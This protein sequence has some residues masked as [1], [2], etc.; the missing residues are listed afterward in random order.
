MDLGLSGHRA[1]VTGA[2]RGIGL[3]IAEQLAAEGCAL[4]LCARTDGPLQETATQLRDRFGVH[5]AATA[6]DVRDGDA[7][8]TWVAS[9]AEALG[10]L[11]IV[12]SNVSAQLS[13]SGEQLWRDTF[14]NDVLQHVRLV[15]AA[16]PHLRASSAASVVYV[17]SIASSLAQLPPTEFVY[18]SMKAALVN[19]AGQL[20]LKHGRD[21]I[22]FNCVSPGPV[23]A[24][25]GVWEQVQTHLPELFAKVQQGTALGRL[26]SAPEIARAVAFLASPAASY[27]TGTNLRVDG[28]TLKT[29]N[30]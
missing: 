6:L 3:A 21:G 16:L 7:V 24:P 10:G 11:D 5:V 8:R 23:L 12:V 27:C 17:A 9:S 19:H 2:S 26:A 22:R 15:D 1:L 4:A 30:F 25:G 14:D 28:G 18:G 13:G 20:A 29:V